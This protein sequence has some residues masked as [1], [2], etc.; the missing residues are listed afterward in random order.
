[1][2]QVEI[3][4]AVVADFPAL[5]DIDHGY[6]TFYVWQMDMHQEE[7]Q[8][9]VSFREIRLPRPVR[10]EFPRPYQ[11]LFTQAGARSVILVG[12][13]DGKPAGYIHISTDLAP[14]TAWVLA[15]AVCEERRRQGIARALIVA[16]QDWA[17]SRH[18]RRMVLEIQ[19]KNLPAIRMAQKLGYEFSGYNDHYYTN[20]DI[21]LFFSQYL[22]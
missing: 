1:M 16:G 14:T 5:V 2:P 13:C 6:K 11:E 12:S 10:V 8:L 3:R 7:G 17:R 18:M 9:G 4:P 20:Q 19:S 15:M 22:R 21:A